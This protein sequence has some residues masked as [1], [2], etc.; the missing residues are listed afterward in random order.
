MWIK[1]ARNPFWLA[2][3]VFVSAVM[4]GAD[5]EKWKDWQDDAV[6][7]IHSG[8][9]PLAEGVYPVPVRFREPLRQMGTDSLDYPNPKYTEATIV[10]AK[11]FPPLSSVRTVRDAVIVASGVASSNDSRSK[12]ECFTVFVPQYMAK[13]NILIEFY[14]ANG[15]CTGSYSPTSAEFAAAS[16]TD[17]VMQLDYVVSSNIGSKTERVRIGR[18]RL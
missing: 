16:R 8:K 12:G 2:M 10:I 7:G 11:S 18:N 15:V 1:L 9:T 4:F 14:D 6:Y 3:C 5:F 13:G 17:D